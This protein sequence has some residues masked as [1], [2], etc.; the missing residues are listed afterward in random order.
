MTGADSRQLLA[1]KQSAL[2][3]ALVRGSSVPA[4]FDARGVQRAARALVEK[5]SRAAAKAFPRLTRSLGQAWSAHFASFAATTSLAQDPNAALDARRFAR[6]LDAR[7]LLTD[8]GR[9]EALQFDLRF[10]VRAGH[11]NLRRGLAL[12]FVRLRQPRQL[13][14]GFR[15]PLVG[16]RIIAFPQIF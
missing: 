9:L 11:A 12:R 14:L 10:A 6:W 16:I 3:A 4:G 5:R 8:D 15:C 13:I 2:V 1:D 7:N